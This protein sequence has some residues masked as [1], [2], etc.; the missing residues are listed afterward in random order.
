MNRRCV[1]ALS[2]D[3]FWR[4]AVAKVTIKDVVIK[5]IQCPDGYPDCLERLPKADPEAL[6]FA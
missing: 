4:E 6:L 5:P 1:Y 2:Q 3:R